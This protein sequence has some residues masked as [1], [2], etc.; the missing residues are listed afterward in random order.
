MADA[1]SSDWLVRLGRALARGKSER[2]PAN[3]WD[4]AEKW[5]AIIRTA[6]ATL[7]SFVL[8]AMRLAWGLELFQ[9]GQGHLNN[10]DAMTKRF[11]QWGVPFPHANVYIS[12]YTEEIG[13]ILWMLGLATRLVSVPLFFNFCVAY[14]TASIGVVKNFFHMPTDFVDDAAF[15]FLITSLVMLAMGPGWISVDGL[16]RWIV[17]LTAPKSP[18]NG[19]AASGGPMNPGV[20]QT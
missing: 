16:I 2:T 5:A 10:V 7:G 4:S 14:L 12:A 20:A 11:E 6:G 19:I 15:P 13:G 1:F 8:L 3:P 9:S 17:N 18:A